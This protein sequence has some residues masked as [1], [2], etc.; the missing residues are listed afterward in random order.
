QAAEELKSFSFIE[1][2]DKST[3]RKET[4][5]VSGLITPW[6]FPTNHTATKIASAFAAG[7]PVILK[8]AE[9][10]SFAAM[11]LADIFEAAVL[12]KGVFNLVNGSGEGIGNGISSHP[13]I[14]FVSFTGSGAVGQKVME[15]AA[16]TIKKVALE[17]GGKSPMIVLDD[18]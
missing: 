12:P 15:N 11:M 6:N 16:K 9:V 3:D 18:A 13:D 2:R 5:G 7:S 8:Q 4:I 1:K 17:L 10:T 14:D